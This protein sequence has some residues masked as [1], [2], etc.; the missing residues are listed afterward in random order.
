M[1]LIQISRALDWAA[2]HPVQRT[3]RTRNRFLAVQ[4]QKQIQFKLAVKNFRKMEHLAGL[5]LEKFGRSHH[6]LRANPKRSYP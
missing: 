5:A 4:E 6:S 2:A 3:L 1:H